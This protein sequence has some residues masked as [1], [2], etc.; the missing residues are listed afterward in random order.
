MKELMERDEQMAAQIVLQYV[1]G[2]FTVAERDTFTREEV[3]VLLNH[4]RTDSDIFDPAVVI[5]AEELDTELRAIEEAAEDP[6]TDKIAVSPAFLQKT[7]AELEEM[8]S[9]REQAEAMMLPSEPEEV[10]AMGA[11]IA[12]GLDEQIRLVKRLLGGVLGGTA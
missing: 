11:G 4:A 9:Q 12:L 5:E 1:I 7:L 8:Q 6:E 10:R 2:L 3:L